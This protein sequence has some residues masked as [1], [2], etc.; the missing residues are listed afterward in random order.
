MTRSL[1]CYP[2]I[3]S[4][5]GVGIH[6]FGAVGLFQV[7]QPRVIHAIMLTIDLLVVIGLS[8]RAHWGYWLAISLYIEQSIMQPYW[9]YLSLINYD[10]WYQLA[11]VCPLVMTA[12]VVL[13]FNK[14]L[15]VRS[16]R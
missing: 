16:P 10:A 14:R 3:L 7:E 15:F 11:I 13:A 9:G 8:K 12:L 1:Y 4:A 5:I 2:I 6:F